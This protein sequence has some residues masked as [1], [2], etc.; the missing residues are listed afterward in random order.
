MR[1]IIAASPSGS[2]Q[3]SGSD[4]GTIGGTFSSADIVTPN[5]LIAGQS[6]TL[7]N[8]AIHAV[9]WRPAPST[10]DACKSEGWRTFGVFV[11]QGDCVSYV[12][13]NG[14]NGGR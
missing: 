7:G 4:L 13:S 9:L 14:S 6:T 11:N 12:V 3:R 1:A 5:G 8:A 2:G 10:A